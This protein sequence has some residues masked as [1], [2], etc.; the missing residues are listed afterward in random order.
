LSAQWSWERYGR[1]SETLAQIEG[2]GSHVSPDNLEWVVFDNEQLLPLYVLH[3]A[4]ENTIRKLWRRR[5]FLA[6]SK[7]PESL[8][9]QW[10]HLGSPILK[11]ITKY[12]RQQQK[13]RGTRK[14]IEEFLEAEDARQM[15][16]HWECIRRSGN[17]VKKSSV[18][19]D[20]PFPQDP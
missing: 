15:G 1:R 6:K 7:E 11:N 16:N 12:A 5:T 9:T 13:R 14:P 10:M 18:S 17:K 3:L 4:P 2:Y 20:Q 19:V 8:E